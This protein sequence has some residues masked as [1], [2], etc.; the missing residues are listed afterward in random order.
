MSGARWLAARST[1]VLAD[2]A[3]RLPEIASSWSL[4]GRRSWMKHA[5]CFLRLRGL[6]APEGGSGRRNLKFDY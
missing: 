5:F 4:A 1:V 3:R 2:A 6:S